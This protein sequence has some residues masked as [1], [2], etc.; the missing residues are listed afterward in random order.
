MSAI[1]A[2]I[3]INVLSNFATDLLKHLRGE[4]AGYLDEAIASTAGAFPELE[5]LADSLRDWMAQPATQTELQEVIEGSKSVIELPTQM[6][7]SE[8]LDRTQFYVAEESRPVAEKVIATFFAKLRAAYIQDPSGQGLLLVANRQ[9]ANIQQQNDGFRDL[10]LQLSMLAAGIADSGGLRQTLR[11]HLEAAKAKLDG[12]LYK[13]AAALFETLLVEIEKSSIRDV[14]LEREVHVSLGRIYTALVENALAAKHYRRAVEIDDDRF[15]R[16]VNSAVASLL[17][18]RP[19][20]A[21]EGL[22]SISPPSLSESFEFWSAKVG[23]LIHLMRDEEAIAVAASISVTGREGARQEILGSALLVAGK[24]AEA[25]TAFRLAVAENAKRPERLA[26]LA[27]A[28]FRGALLFRSA[29]PG[30]PFSEKIKVQLA[31]S[32]ALLERCVPLLRAQEREHGASEA[33]G[34]L[35]MVYALNGKHQEAIRELEAVAGS[36]FARKEDRKNLGL[37]YLANNAPREAA[38][39]FGELVSVEPEMEIEI[40]HLKAL[41]FS[42][43]SDR[44]LEVCAQR[45][46]L[47]ITEANMLWHVLRSEVLASKRQYSQAR[48]ALEQVCARFPADVDVLL[49]LAQLNEVAA[50]FDGAAEMYEKALRNATGE[51]ENQVR[52]RY[53]GFCATRRDSLKAAELWRPLVDVSRSGPLLDDFMVALYNSGQFGEVAQIA[54]QQRAN[55]QPVSKLFADVSSAAYEQLDALVE[56]SFWLEYL[57]DRHGNDPRYLVRLSKIKM[58]LGKRQEAEELLDITRSTLTSSNDLMGYAQGYLFLGR[59]ADALELAHR[60][61]ILSPE[62]HDLQMEFVRIFLKIPEDVPKSAEQIATGQDILANYGQRFPNSKSLWSVQIDR[63]DPLAAVRP[64]LEQKAQRATAA[65]SLYT[66]KHLPLPIF[67]RMLGFDIYGC[68]LSIL[69]SPEQSFYAGTGT[70][71]EIGTFRRLLE[72]GTCFIVEAVSLFTLHYLG[73]EENLREIGRIFIVQH[74]TDRLHAILIERASSGRESGSL[75]LH[76]GEPFFVSISADDAVK[77]NLNLERSTTFAE[78]HLE[79]VGLKELFSAQDEEWMTVLPE[80]AVATLL[81]GKQYNFTMITDDFSFGE[82]GLSNYGVSFVNT[83]AIL[84]Y[85]LGMGK[86]NQDQFDQAIVR[87]VDAGFTFLRVTDGQFFSIL[88]EEAFQIT[89]RVRRV[90][91]ILE[92]S[93]ADA[94][95]LWITIACLV[96]RLYLEPLPDS[97]RE[98]LLFFILDRAAQNRSKLEVLRQVRHIVRQQMTPL[99]MFQLAAVENAL[100]KW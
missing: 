78:N 2:T 62:N 25:E 70:K 68:W 59:H 98:N 56:A 73:M 90:F 47:P 34:N 26:L 88:I 7:V 55:E 17:E 10:K 91:R 41:Q 96:R 94:F 69:A 75:G 100:E 64:Y 74:A 72:S 95:S 1:I 16:V 24:L 93:T 80:D 36:E 77:A 42:G 50:D 53:G 86:I 45:A 83:E 5:G 27:D 61:A 33:Q 9:E 28:L 82:I 38:R 23:A 71:E 13:S 54:Q 29:H 14:V 85:L 31:E 92:T 87:L 3:G 60:S 65:L 35:G 49:S 21:L 30:S 63:D 12:C 99:L 40:M 32:Q 18:G 6:L 58:R 97:M 46:T 19:S 43:Q 66:E 57:C 15:R 22:D 39:I 4:P 20:E 79:I 44:A 52:F 11:T 84:N 37:E 89:P 8:L 67:S 76:E 51:R 48:L 81:A